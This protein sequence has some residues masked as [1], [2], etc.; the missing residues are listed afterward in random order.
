VIDAVYIHSSYYEALQVTVIDKCV[1]RYDASWSEGIERLLKFEI[2]RSNI[3]GLEATWNV[4]KAAS[5]ALSFLD[6]EGD[7]SGDE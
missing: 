7:R 6:N 2:N 4:A 3:E 1:E 5:T